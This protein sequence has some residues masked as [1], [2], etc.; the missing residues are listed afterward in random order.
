MY[1][2]FF[3]LSLSA[4]RAWIEMVKL[5][6]SYNCS[7]VALRKESVDRNIYDNLHSKAQRASLSARRAWIEIDGSHH[8]GID[9]KQSLSARRA[10]IEIRLCR[11]C[12]VLGRVALRKESVDRNGVILDGLDGCMVALRKESVDRNSIEPAN[13]T[14]STTSL[15]ARRAW[16]EISAA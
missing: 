4:R 5:A 13:L 1:D 11:C 9:T 8:G 7:K 6:V 3:E 10:W 15:S 16:I 14:V 12:R 2:D